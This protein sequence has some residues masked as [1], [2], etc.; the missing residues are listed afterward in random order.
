MSD[1]V[2]G[3]A[4]FGARPFGFGGEDGGEVFLPLPEGSGQGLRVVTAAGDLSLP[5]PEVAES[6]VRSILSA[7]GDV[8]LPV[9]TAHGGSHIVEFAYGDP[10]LPAPEA[11]GS[12]SRTVTGSGEADPPRPTAYGRVRKPLSGVGDAT[13]PSPET[14]AA[15]RGIRIVS[16]SGAVDLPAPEAASESGFRRFASGAVD[17]PSLAVDGTVSRGAVSGQGEYPARARLPLPGVESFSSNKLVTARG[18]VPLPRAA[19]SA[20]GF[21]SP[22]YASGAAVLP[23]VEASGTGRE[24]PH[25]P[26]DV[27]SFLPRDLRSE[28]L[29]ARFIPLVEHLL[30]EYHYRILNRVAGLYD[31]FH[32]SFDADRAIQSLG[33]LTAPLRS[34][35]DDQKRTLFLLLGLLNR[36]KGMRSGV[37]GILSAM[38]YPATLFEADDVR[39]EV[40]TGLPAPHS[41]LGA[42]VWTKIPDPCSVS[43]VFDVT[44]KPVL[45]KDLDPDAVDE[46]EILDALDRIVWICAKVKDFLYLMRFEDRDEYVTLD[47]AAFQSTLDVCSKFRF[48]DEEDGCLDRPIL[49]EDAALEGVDE[50]EF[51]LAHYAERFAAAPV[52]GAEIYGAPRYRGRLFP[53]GENDPWTLNPEDGSWTYRGARDG[54]P[55]ANGR[56]TPLV[57]LL[58]AYGDGTNEPLPEGLYGLS[59]ECAGD[60]ETVETEIIRESDAYLD[61]L[62]LAGDPRFVQSP[63]G[64]ALRF[65]PP[66][67]ADLSVNGGKTTLP[68]FPCDGHALLAIYP[69]AGAGTVTV[70]R[71]SVSRYPEGAILPSASFANV[72]DMGKRYWEKAPVDGKRGVAGPDGR[73]WIF[74]DPDDPPALEFPNGEEEPPVL[75]LAPG[76]RAVYRATAVD[77]AVDA[78]PG[79]EDFFYPDDPVCPLDPAFRVRDRIGGALS[80]SGRATVSE[81]TLVVRLKIAGWYGRDRDGSPLRLDYLFEQTLSAFAGTQEFS[82]V[83]DEWIPLAPSVVTVEVETGPDGEAVV[84]NLTLNHSPV[85]ADPLWVEGSPLFPSE[86]IMDVPET[87]R[88]FAFC[89]DIFSEQSAFWKV[90]CADALVCCPERG[91][92]DEDAE[93]GLLVGDLTPGDAWVGGSALRER[94]TEPPELVRIGDETVSGTFTGEAFT[95]DFALEEAEI[96]LEADVDPEDGVFLIAPSVSGRPTGVPWPEGAPVQFRAYLDGE[97]PEGYELDRAYYVIPGEETAPGV[98]TLQLAD[99]YED[100]LDGTALPVPAPKSGR[101]F[102]YGS[103]LPPALRVP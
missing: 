15:S 37:E 65:G 46:Q 11:S 2:F 83:P 5:V 96:D 67:R 99:T 40:E 7:S 84:E 22:V 76:Q 93:D 31:V 66:I 73:G 63:E 8:A 34:L 54:N 95:W 53:Q 62:L 26:F 21:V 1:N 61:A 45:T 39:W 82:V 38:G 91:S 101:A 25:I 64:D 10:V 90:P 60:G 85:E 100:A 72:L 94:L 68:A 88:Y 58:S 9:P 77:A 20:H 48:Q 28:P 23:S 80:L 71:L 89:G 102:L 27:A 33:G 51:V 35:T 59:L 49:V 78:P 50:S 75:R 18:V 70:K 19:A 24:R 57:Y 43:V 36:V 32:A 4:P 79:T 86:W 16:G 42:P 17:L 6:D 44:G 81:G 13:L 30:A 55:P 103:V 52:Y 56:G 12:G 98:F 97:A 92:D 41:P 87:E 69:P 74:D 29:Y 3:G 47:E 14:G